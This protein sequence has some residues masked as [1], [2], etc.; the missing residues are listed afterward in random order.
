MLHKVHNTC[1]RAEVGFD[2]AENEPRQVCC[3]IRAREPLLRHSLL[4]SLC[5]RANPASAGVPQPRVEQGRDGEVGEAQ[6][7]REAARSPRLGHSGSKWESRFLPHPLSS[8]V[9]RDSKSQMFENHY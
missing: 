4:L 1:L 9:E 3:T 7:L 8:V 6:G 5:P 2:I